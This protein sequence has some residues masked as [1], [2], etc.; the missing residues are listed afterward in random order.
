MCKKGAKI[1]GKMCKM[2]TKNLEKM[3]TNNYL[4]DK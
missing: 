2:S 4:L 3:C 1:Y